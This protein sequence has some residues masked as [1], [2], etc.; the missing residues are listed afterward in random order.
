MLGALQH[1]PRTYDRQRY[2]LMAMPLV[3]ITADGSA[4]VIKDALFVF[5]AFKLLFCVPTS[6][7]DATLWSL[8][9]GR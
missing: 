3:A 4:I 7:L 6:N 8:F 1:A 9:S 5:F 2:F